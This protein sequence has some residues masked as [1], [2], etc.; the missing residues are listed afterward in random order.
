MNVFQLTV[1]IFYTFVSVKDPKLQFIFHPSDRKNC[2]MINTT[3]LTMNVMLERSPDLDPRIT[4]KPGY[5]QAQIIGM[6]LRHVIY[7]II[8]SIY[9]LLYLP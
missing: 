6:L 3:N 7:F 8:V 4:F 5:E 1:H 2:I 9:H